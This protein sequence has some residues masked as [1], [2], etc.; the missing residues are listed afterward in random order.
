MVLGAFSSS[1]LRPRTLVS[2]LLLMA[3]APV[4]LVAGCGERG[5]GPV[6]F[7][8]QVGADQWAFVLAEGDGERVVFGA[9]GVTNTGEEPAT[10]LD[11]A[12][13][14]PDDEVVDGGARLDE[15]L[16]REVGEGEDYLG[17][18]PTWPV[19]E[20]AD[21]AVPIAGYELAPGATVEVLYVVEV[22]EEGT[23]FWPRSEVTYTSDGDRYR[24]ATSTGFLICP[25]DSQG[26]CDRP[27][28]DD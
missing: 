17:A 18:A 3:L 19:E 9:L 12:L 1:S 16:V 21:D 5:R 13:T 25:P 26:A 15:V 6:T 24:D 14:G 4:V 11:G 23:W 28:S 2:A 10:L 27:S 22:E 8:S 7:G 20:Y